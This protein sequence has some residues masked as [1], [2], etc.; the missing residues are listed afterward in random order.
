MKSKTKAYAGE[1]ICVDE[2]EYD[3]YQVMG[4]F[5]VTKEFDIKQQLIEYLKTRPGQR[6]L[7]GFRGDGFLRHLLS[8]G[9]L[10]GINY[11]TLHLGSY[12]NS[13]RVQFSQESS[14]DLDYILKEEKHD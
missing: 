13:H 4:F 8:L 5:V 1:I 3:D 14:E 11:K 2:G 6:E 10:A 7:G 9:V 12:G